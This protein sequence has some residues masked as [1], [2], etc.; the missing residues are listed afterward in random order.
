ML[1]SFPDS[2]RD[3]DV[4]TLV[5]MMAGRGKVQVQWLA[6]AQL[7]V[8]CFL[9]VLDAR[10]CS[11]Y[12]VTSWQHVPG[13]C[14]G[15]ATTTTS[16]QDE[17]NHTD[18]TSVCFASQMGEEPSDGGYLYFA[19]LFIFVCGT[20]GQVTAYSTENNPAA[21]KDNL[22][23]C[24]QPLTWTS[25]H[26][27][28]GF[29]DVRHLYINTIYLE[30]TLPAPLMPS[31][32]LLNHT[33][34][35]S[36]T[37]TYDLIDD[38]WT[39]TL[40]VQQLVAPTT[41][42]NSTD[43]V[44]VS[45]ELRPQASR[46]SARPSLVVSNLQS[47]TRYNFRLCAANAQRAFTCG[48]P[49]YNVSTLREPDEPELSFAAKVSISTVSAAAALLFTALL[50]LWLWNRRARRERAEYLALVHKAADEQTRL[51]T[52]WEISEHDLQL[53][54]A[55]AEG[56]FGVVWRA[57]YMD[58]AVAVKKLKAV[59]AMLD[60]TSKDEFLREA[61][62]LRTLRHRNIVFFYG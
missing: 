3:V 35:T 29:P 4:R 38:S 11:M 61:A 54:E 13:T 49:V 41:N 30:Y 25:S 8:L 5:I 40:F 14:D 23:V 2:K 19:D 10:G 39:R 18:T 16:V 6:A 26:T 51:N 21:E 58:H 59:M 9:P 12:G 57:Q 50:I 46:S 45:F 43:V 55:V 32:L 34:P 31:P 17:F 42:F 33:S 52:V 20:D 37:F 1:L 44:N 62:A 60:D 27:C 53:E 28:Q 36:A 56:S 22:P 48:P 24:N 7:L 47:H 15:T